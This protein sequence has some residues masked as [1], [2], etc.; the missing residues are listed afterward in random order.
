MSPSVGLPYSALSGLASFSLSLSSSTIYIPLLPPISKLAYLP[1]LHQQSPDY[2]I[3]GL[4]QLLQ[5]HFNTSTPQ[6]PITNQH[7]RHACLRVL[8]P[9]WRH[10]C[11]QHHLHRLRSQ[12][13][14]QLPSVLN[15]F[16]E[17]SL[18]RRQLSHSFSHCFNTCYRSDQKLQHHEMGV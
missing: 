16:T 12:A 10:D 6:N 17:E 15:A 5:H 1:L 4:L 13:V 14:Q 18:R 7:H 8:L 11:H 3:P 2:T 9:V